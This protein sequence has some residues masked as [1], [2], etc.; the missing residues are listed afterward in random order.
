MVVC[1]VED[2]VLK[3]SLAGFLNCGTGGADAAAGVPIPGPVKELLDAPPTAGV[4]GWK[5][6]NEGLL[7][8]NCDGV[9]ENCP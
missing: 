7:V 1:V 3:A 4:E 5:E 6:G 9:M 8:V 2:V